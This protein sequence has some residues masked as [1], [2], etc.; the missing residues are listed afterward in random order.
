MSRHEGEGL[1]IRLT[2]D[3][4]EDGEDLGRRSGKKGG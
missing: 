2:E 3:V 4:G 1:R